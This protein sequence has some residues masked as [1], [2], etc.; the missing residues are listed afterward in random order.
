MNLTIVRDI[1]IVFLALESIVVGVVLVL[2]L[3]QVRNLTR[4]VQEQIKPMLDSMRETV[5]TVKG[6]ASLVSETIVTPAVK[7]SGFFAGA[8]RA[9]QVMLSL[10]SPGDGPAM[11]PESTDP[12]QEHQPPDGK[13]QPGSK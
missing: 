7:I 1:A 11:F 12:A 6:T 13:G 8:R 4:L 2:L 5:G 9:L 10:R 3:W